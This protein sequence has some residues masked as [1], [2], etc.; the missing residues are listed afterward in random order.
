MGRPLRGKKAPLPRSGCPTGAPLREKKERVSVLRCSLFL[1]TQIRFFA[2]SRSALFL[3]ITSSSPRTASGS[4]TIRVGRGRIMCARGNCCVSGRR[5][6]PTKSG[7]SREIRTTASVAWRP[8]KRWC[9]RRSSSRVRNAG[10]SG[11][12]FTNTVEERVHHPRV[13]DPADARASGRD[14]DAVS[15]R[16][17]GES[18]QGRGDGGTDA[19]GIAYVC[20]SAVHERETSDAVDAA[21]VVVFSGL[22][23]GHPEVDCVHGR[24]SGEGAEAATKLALC[25]AVLG[26]VF[27]S[28]V[29]FY[30]P[31]SG[32]PR[33]ARFTFAQPRVPRWGNRYAA[34]EYSRNPPLSSTTN[35]AAQ[36]P[37]GQISGAPKD[38]R[39]FRCGNGGFRNTSTPP[40]NSTRPTGYN[41]TRPTRSPT[42]RSA[43]RARSRR[44]SRWTR[45]CVPSR[46][47]VCTRC[48][49]VR[50][51]WGS[52]R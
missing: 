47:T 17:C 49:A 46:K 44:A 18:A 23:C 22:R 28:R 7:R 26:I 14:A 5:P 38:D 51:F 32:R 1:R 52:W 30:S 40:Y 48:P 36:E 13:L 39:V 6:R 15:H 12:G 16:A 19:P 4:P 11:W 42:S 9:A 29:L 31:R 25:D 37:C 24:E 8:R 20:G 41:R 2:C 10:R 3:R 27:L 45:F 50:R 21:R 34:E 35:K 33:G 43:A